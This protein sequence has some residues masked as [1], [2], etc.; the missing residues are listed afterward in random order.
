[1]N[2]WKPFRSLD[3]RD[4]EAVRATVRLLTWNINGLRKVAASYGGLKV[5]LDQFKADVGEDRLYAFN[6]LFAMYSKTSR[7]GALWSGHTCCCNS[8]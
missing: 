6:F 5:L 4:V 8:I 1:M 3:A 7:L 2:D